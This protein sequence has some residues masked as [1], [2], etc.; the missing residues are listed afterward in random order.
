M[1]LNNFEMV[2][3]MAQKRLVE[4]G[5]GENHEGKESCLMKKV[6]VMLSENTRPRM[7]KTCG[8]IG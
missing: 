7:K 5:K 8:A 2:G 3:L 6:K 1:L 4:L